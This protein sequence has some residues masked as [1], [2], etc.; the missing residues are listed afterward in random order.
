MRANRRK[1][2][3]LQHSVNIFVTMTVFFALALAIVGAT[4]WGIAEGEE[5]RIFV[6]DGMPNTEMRMP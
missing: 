2:T 4:M 1:P 3:K 5:V 6:T